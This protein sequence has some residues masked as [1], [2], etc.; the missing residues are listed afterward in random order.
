MQISQIKPH[1]F[2]DDHIPLCAIFSHGWGVGEVTFQHFQTRE[3]ADMARYKRFS[4]AVE[5]Q[6]WMAGIT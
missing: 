4:I 6:L 2:F 3:G 5:K 1:E